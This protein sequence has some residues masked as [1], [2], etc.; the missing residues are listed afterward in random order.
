[1]DYINRKQR[2]TNQE[3][4]N[5]WGAL[6]QGDYETACEIFKQQGDW[7]NC[8]DKSKEKSPEL[9]NKYLN[10]FIK[11]TVE[12]GKF[13]DAAQAYA[14]YGMQLIPKNYPTYKMLAMEIFV[15]CERAEV[16]P[17]RKALFDFFKLLESTNDPGNPTLQEF[18]KFA[19]VAHLI[20]LKFQYEAKPAAQG[21]HQRITIALL[22]YCDYIRLDKVF[23]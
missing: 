6:E 14:D 3:K 2:D 19:Q 18:Y 8:L 13:A 7:K 20:N 22:R 10:E 9:L 4:G 1:M 11:I 23:Y 15:E 5:A 17:L 21:L 16:V 12:G